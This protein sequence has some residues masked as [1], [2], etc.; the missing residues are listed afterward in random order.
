[1]NAQFYEH[2]HRWVGALVYYNEVTLQDPNSPYANDARE[3]IDAIKKRL[4]GTSK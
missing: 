3:R 2:R 1:M 4:E